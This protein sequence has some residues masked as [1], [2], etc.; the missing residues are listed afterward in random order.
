VNQAPLY[1]IWLIIGIGILLAVLSYFLPTQTQGDNRT[2]DRCWK[3]GIFYVNP[4][5]SALFVPKRF[6]I[7][8]TLDF[9]NPWSWAVLAL[10]GVVAVVPIFVAFL[11]VLHVLGKH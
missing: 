2:P 4:D 1:I 8:Y 5:D 3:A 10:V 6:G 9:G 7:G 11:S